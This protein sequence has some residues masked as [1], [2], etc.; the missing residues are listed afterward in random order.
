MATTVDA[1]RC[2]ELISR[3]RSNK[4]SKDPNFITQFNAVW[5]LLGRLRLSRHNVILCGKFIVEMQDSW[6]ERDQ[7]E[8]IDQLRERQARSWKR[9]EKR[10]AEKQAAKASAGATKRRS[11]TEAPVQ[12]P[13]APENDPWNMVK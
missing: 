1:A 10:I 6:K 5:H 2:A 8:M 3:Y 11:K 13:P 12:A 7:L 9:W 4:Q